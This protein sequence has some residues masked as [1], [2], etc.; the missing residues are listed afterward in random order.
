MKAIITVE[1]NNEAFVG[2]VGNELARILRRLADNVDYPDLSAG[3]RETCVDYNGNTV[4]QF[5]VEE[6]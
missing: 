4:G 1:M 3:F 2:Y 5:V 6:D